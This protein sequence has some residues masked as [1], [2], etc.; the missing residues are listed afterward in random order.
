MTG[1]SGGTSGR[2]NQGAGTPR[3]KAV[4]HKGGREWSGSRRVGAERLPTPE[5]SAVRLSGPL[6]LTEPQGG[7]RLQ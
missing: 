3:Q 5:L 7:A 4:P 2:Q 1:T 6:C